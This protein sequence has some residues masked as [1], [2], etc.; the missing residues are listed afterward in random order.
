MDSYR[1]TRASSNGMPNYAPAVPACQSNA[2]PRAGSRSCAPIVP[3][4]I[5]S[6]RRAR[7]RPGCATTLA[8]TW[9]AAS[10]P[11][12]PSI[13]T[14]ASPSQRL[15]RTTISSSPRA[16]RS[17]TARLENCRPWPGPISSRT[18]TRQRIN[19]SWSG[20][21][22]ASRSRAI[23][24][25]ADRGGDAER[26]ATNSHAQDAR[27]NCVHRRPRFARPM[28]WPALSPAVVRRSFEVP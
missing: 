26:R 15:P 5:S 19:A 10:F 27:P 2:Q 9:F 4:A 24:G 14:R 28:R 16:E 8:T 11:Q 12:R 13:A 1:T 18:A 7:L 3:S 6:R 25:A 23:S 22:F 20:R 21:A 17:V